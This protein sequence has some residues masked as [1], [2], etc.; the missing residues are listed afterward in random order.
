[1]R[2]FFVTAAALAAL[3]STSSFITPSEAKTPVKPVGIHKVVKVK[4]GKAFAKV[5]VVCHRGT[6]RHHGRCVA[7]KRHHVGHVG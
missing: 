3:V 4:P 6:W 1:M 5:R 2:K 7:M